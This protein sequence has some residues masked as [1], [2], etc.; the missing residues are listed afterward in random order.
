MTYITSGKRRLY[1]LQ[2]SGLAGYS[3]LGQCKWYWCVAMHGW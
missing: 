3:T 2:Y 1:I